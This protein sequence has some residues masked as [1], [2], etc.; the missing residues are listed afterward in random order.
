VVLD[1][2]ALDRALH[3]AMT[4]PKAYLER[5]GYAPPPIGHVADVRPLDVEVNHGIWIWTCPCGLGSALDPPIGGGVA[6]VERPVGW[7]PRCEN[8]DVDGRWRPL[9]FPS[10]HDAIERLLTLR[11][12]PETRSWWPGETVDE[13]ATQ[14][15]AEGL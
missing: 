2:A 14:N 7:C 11:P 6:F 15:A 5:F 4:D 1:G 8:A 3:G 10:D 13:L 12:E 9:R